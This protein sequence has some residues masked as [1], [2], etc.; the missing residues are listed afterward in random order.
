VLLKSESSSF[1]NKSKNN[2]EVP[3]HAALQ[4]M[5]NTPKRLVL[6]LSCCFTQLC[7]W[8]LSGTV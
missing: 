8:M 2:L 7:L 1:Y 3:T 4:N 6:V 5:T